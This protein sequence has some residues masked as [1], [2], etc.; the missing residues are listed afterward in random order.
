MQKTEWR[1]IENFCD[2]ELFQQAYELIED[3]SP[4][5]LLEP[6]EAGFYTLK[7]KGTSRDDFNTEIAFGKK[8]INQ[9]HCE[10]GKAQKQLCVHLIAAAI[11]YRRQAEAE[12]NSTSSRSR[13]VSLPSRITIP[14]ILNQIPK[15]ELDRFLQRF[16]RT[17]KQ[18]AQA[19]KL[20]FASRIQLSSSEMK[21]HDLIKSM[22][23][24]TPNSLGSIPKAGI[25]SLFWVSEELLLQADDLIAME[26]PTEAFAICIELLTRYH[27]IYRKLEMYI[28]E[29]EKNWVQI[30]QKIK[31]ILTMDL[32]PAFKSEAE[33]R[34]IEIFEDTAYPMIHSPNNLYEILMPMV[35]QSDRSKLNE[36]LLT[37][38]SRKENNPVP[39]AAL[40]R[41]AMRSQDEHM[42]DLAFEAPVDQVKWLGVIDSLYN[43]NKEYSRMIGLWLVRKIK[44]PFWQAKIMDRFVSLFPEDAQSVGFTLQLLKH[45]PEDKQIKYLLDHRVPKERI[46]EAL[47]QSDTSKARLLLINLYV[48]SGKITE[49]KEIID[50]HLTLDLLK[51]YTIKFYPKEIEWLEENYKSLFT[52]YLDEHLGPQSITKIQ[53]LLSYLQMVKCYAL[54]E[55]LQ[56]WIKKNFQDH[57]SL[58]QNI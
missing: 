42:L 29:F 26:N 32:A 9:V 25:Q 18:F 28:G 15:E 41:I 12:G 49:A 6:A 34:L 23:R 17:N 11:L 57:P 33:T 51:S 13:E 2:P 7:N 31:A 47:L 46:F 44:D 50:Q 5:Y 56:K 1:Y 43:A 22:A 45:S 16:A 8:Y 19:L 4:N 27:S 24:L 37:K 20:H 36:V 53:N 54:A 21:Y 30:H 55:N 52:K 39:L 40:T 14:A 10:C 58:L 35:S 48:E 3:E 38:I